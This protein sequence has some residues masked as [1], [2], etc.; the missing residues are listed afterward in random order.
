MTARLLRVLLGVVCACFATSSSLAAATGGTLD[1]IRDTGTITFAY[2]A[3]AAPFS[4]A[5]REG[6][7]RGYSAELCTEIAASIQQRLKLPALKIAWVAVDAADRLETV[8]GGRADAECGTTTMTLSRM[9]KVDFSLPI[10]VDGAT[11]LLRANSKIGKLADLKARKVAVIP[12]TTTEQAL[13]AAMN[14]QNA[15]ATLVPVK[16]GVEGVTLLSSG[17]VDAYAGDRVV[18]AGFKLRDVAKTNLELFGSD[19]SYEPY[20]IVV[21]RDDPDFRLAVNRALAELYK[22]GG[23]D[24]VYQRWLAPL[25]PPGPLLNAMYYLNAIPE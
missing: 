1:R 12:G 4:F 14:L 25:G 3:G 24:Q 15:T 13:V 5:D 2:R 16:D 22:R 23:I 11:L 19:F 6:R 21:R 20:G 9:Q 18:L 10:F 17:K 8:A 7:V